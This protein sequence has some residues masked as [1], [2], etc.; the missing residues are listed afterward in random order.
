[1]LVIWS[2]RTDYNTKINEI[3]R[4]ITDNIHDKYITTPEFSSQKMENKVR[5]FRHYFEIGFK[6]LQMIKKAV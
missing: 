3:E 5:N 6:L 4:K 1:M 2:K